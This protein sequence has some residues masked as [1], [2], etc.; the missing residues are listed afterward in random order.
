MVKPKQQT[1]DPERHVGIDVTNG[2]VKGY[3]Q[4]GSIRNLIRDILTLLMFFGFGGF[5]LV[6]RSSLN[7]AIAK[8]AAC[9]QNMANAKEHL[10]EDK[11]RITRLETQLQDSLNRIMN[12]Q[13]SHNKPPAKLIQR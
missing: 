6:T 9:E 10:A 8:I 12:E 1:T 5:A 4:Y 2:K 13:A 11:E 7:D 3:F